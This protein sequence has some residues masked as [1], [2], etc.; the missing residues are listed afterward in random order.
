MSAVKIS[1]LK[2]DFGTL[3]FH[4]FPLAVLVKILHFCSLCKNREIK[5]TRTLTVSR[6]VYVIAAST[7]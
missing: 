6:Y 3:Y 2:P 1:E 7:L 5:S 4:N